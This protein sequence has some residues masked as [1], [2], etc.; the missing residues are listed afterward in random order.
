MPCPGICAIAFGD[1]HAVAFTIAP[2][3]S[4]ACLRRGF[5][6]DTAG[7]KIVIGALG[8]A[9]AHTLHTQ[10]VITVRGRCAAFARCTAKSIAAI[11]G[12]AGAFV[13]ARGTICVAGCSLDA[14]VFQVAYV[15]RAAAQ[16]V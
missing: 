8:V 3:V 7:L 9:V 10:T 2:V 12:G 6:L 16:I 5:V 1:C 14:L 13:C 4:G 11:I 15:A